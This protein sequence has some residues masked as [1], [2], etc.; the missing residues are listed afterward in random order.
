MEAIVVGGEEPQGEG[1]KGQK[2]EMQGVIS[3]MGTFWKNLT[4]AESA[5]KVL[6]SFGKDIETRLSDYHYLSDQ[7]V[8][9]KSILVLC[10]FRFCGIC[11]FFKV[12]DTCG[13]RNNLPNI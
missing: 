9:I 11:C 1:S 2:S 7:Q 12:S 5:G 4:F 6:E 10:V 8:K 13:C 3:R